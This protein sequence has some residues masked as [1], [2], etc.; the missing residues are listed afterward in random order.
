MTPFVVLLLTFLVAILSVVELK[1][2]IPLGMGLAEGAGLTGISPW[3]YF[4]VA[5]L[6]TCVPALLITLFLKPVLKSLGK[7]KLFKPLADKL[8]AHFARKAERV[9]KKAEVRADRYKQKL[10]AKGSEQAWSEE[11]LA[12]RVAQS[13]KRR[14]TV[15]ELV[16]YASLFLFVAVPLPLTGVW[17]GSA[18]GVFLN[19]KFRYA[20]PCIILGNLVAGLIVMGLSLAG[21]HLAGI[22]ITF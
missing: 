22:T 4:A 5:F 2:A 19:T 12:A 20:F 18:I 7:T 17:T 1:L 15:L 16:K 3:L 8:D 11:K 6:G 9:E 13:E 21:F 10:L 14:A